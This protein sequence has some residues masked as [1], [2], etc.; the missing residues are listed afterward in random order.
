MQCDVD[1]HCGVRSFRGLLPKCVCVLPYA[2]ERKSQCDRNSYCRK[3]LVKISF[4]SLV[5]KKEKI[6]VR[7]DPT[8]KTGA[9]NAQ[10]GHHPGS[11]VFTTASSKRPI[12]L[13]RSMRGTLTSFPAAVH[14]VEPDLRAALQVLL[15]GR[16]LMVLLR[17]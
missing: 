2:G 15:S 3:F 1:E 9:T 17:R 14:R 10:M 4:S 7:H 13:R 6:T 12:S 8:M 5:R 11:P 16:E